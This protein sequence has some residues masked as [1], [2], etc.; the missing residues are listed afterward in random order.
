MP[1]R[2]PG[3]GTVIEPFNESDAAAGN[4][5]PADSGSSQV[6]LPGLSEQSASSDPD[7]QF[8]RSV[9]RIGVQVAEALEYAN[10]QG[11]LHRDIKPSNLLLDNHGNVWVADFGLAKTA[12][13]D[14]LTH[15]GDILGTIRYMAP[16]R[17]SGHCDA[18]SDVYSLGLTLYELVALRPAYEAADRHTLIDRVLHE[19]PERLRKLA[20]GVPRDLETIVAKASSR[21][22]SL[23][24][25]TAGALADD[26]RRFI[27]DR[28][29]RARRVSPAE[30]FARWCRRNKLLAVSIGLATAALL[31]V[32]VLAVLYAG[33]QTHR[34]AAQKRYADEQTRRAD[35]QAE[36]TKTITRMAVNLEEQGKALKALLAESNRRLAMLNFEKGRAAFE[37]GQ[38]GPGMLWMAA[39]LRNAT[40]AGDTAWKQA[41]LTSLAAW[42]PVHT[43]IRAV[44]SLDGPVLQVAFSSDG[45]TILTRS[46]D[47]TVRLWDA[48]SARPIGPPIQHQQRIIGPPMQHQH[49]IRAAVFSPDGKSILTGGELTARLWDART[50][51]PIGQPMPD[52]R[53][54][55]MAVEFSP[56]G[57]TVLTEGLDQ[58]TYRW[59]AFTGLAIDLPM[60][61]DDFYA[62]A[63]SP[64]CRTALTIGLNAPWKM[65]LWDL[66][67]NRPIGRPVEH[68]RCIMQAIFSPDGKTV[69]VVFSPGVYSAD[70]RVS[71]T[72]LNA[73]IQTG[74][75]DA[76]TGR[77]LGDPLN[78]EGSGSVLAFSPDG[79]TIL[80]AGVIRLRQAWS[81]VTAKPIGRPLVHQDDVLAGTFSPDGR[82]ILTGSAD[83]TARLWD[84]GCG[85]AIGEPMQHQDAVSAVAFSPDGKAVL[86][87]SSDKTARL[88]D[89]GLD[90]SSESPWTSTRAMHRHSRERSSVPMGG[91]SSRQASTTPHDCG[92]PPRADPSACL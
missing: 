44:F 9:A 4:G 50:G 42:R 80:T 51:L 75:W 13:A 20:P 56:D 90:S 89:A 33:E 88:W 24:Y 69:R 41:A 62:I 85:L 5:S 71:H 74:L 55:V 91:P 32:T 6:F 57:K 31:V 59:D 78:Y 83:R 7:R 92:T 14:D 66:E 79:K 28:P 76:S 23:R 60:W 86:T 47:G 82:T 29:I 25:A 19:E 81:A 16:E 30:R 39:T 38:V 15:S 3:D 36:A 84:A 87:G 12:E 17:F 70:R 45:K 26:L 54:E 48:I 46:D 77:P 61:H 18:R 35:D 58:R 63:F 27:E 73:G 34:A 1:V 8:F 68:Q 53:G 40:E 49:G 37:R 64:D 72:G 11:I 43:S 10:R 21:E 2:P 65:R 22:P 67:R 52:P